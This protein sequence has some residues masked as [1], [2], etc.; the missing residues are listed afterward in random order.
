M[1][2]YI[3]QIKERLEAEPDKTLE[4]EIAM[5]DAPKNGTK[6]DG[7][8]FTF[9]PY[10]FTLRATGEHVKRNLFEN[11]RKYITKALP[12]A[13][14]RAKL[15]EKG[16]INWSVIPSGEEAL[17]IENTREGFRNVLPLI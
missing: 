8:P 12:G 17:G 9:Y 7:T 6:K 3:D 5:I 13:L 4:L 10:T 14:V 1:A 11:E 2:T 15:N 16:F